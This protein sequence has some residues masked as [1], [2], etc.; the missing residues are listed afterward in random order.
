MKYLSI[1][2]LSVIFISCDEES[3]SYLPSYTGQQG[4]LIAV[5]DPE[6]INSSINDTL[7][8]ALNQ[9]LFGLPQAE[10]MFK[11]VDLKPKSFTRIFR[12]HRNIVRF[13]LDP[14]SAADVKINNDV[15]AKLQTI[16]TFKAPDLMSM[17]ELVLDKI[18]Q[19]LWLFHRRELD[20][21]ISRNQAFGNQLLNDRVAGSMGIEIVTQKDMEVAKETDN[22]M[23]LRLDR[24]KPLGGYQHQISQG[25]LIYS[26]PY[27]DTNQFSDSSLLA[28]KNEVNK[29]HVNGP[30][31]SHMT[32]SFK[33]YNPVFNYIK[34]RGET[35]REFRGL[36][37]MEGYFMGG[38]FY[39][40]SFF[41]P[42]NG[43]QYMVE[44]YVFAPQFDKRQFLREVE[45]I[46]KSA[47][48]VK[49]KVA[50]EAG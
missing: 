2:L 6:I 19:V 28:W 31:E 3:G 36:W 16:V 12:T 38:P 22:F 41:N 11:V 18:D 40:L 44:G 46:V 26:R 33:L 32:T 35:A 30:S 5:I 1:F 50:Q 7:F 14:K 9:P 21:I 39:A 29:Q 43:R 13:E 10:P 20:R 15:H 42:E 49:T 25:L 47:E 17:R 24:E 4:E 34:F 23:W 45:A 27:T 37:R 48:P 8:S